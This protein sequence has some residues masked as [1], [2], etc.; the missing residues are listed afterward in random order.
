[1][2]Y[3]AGDIICFSSNDIFSIFVKIFTL[4]DISHVGIMID[5][6][7]MLEAIP[8]RIRVINIKDKLSE[9]NGTAY[10]CSLKKKHRTMIELNKTKFDKCV[11]SLI[12][13]PYD[14]G[15][16]IK[17][18]IGTLTNHKY[19]WEDNKNAEICSETD[20]I[21]LESAG[22]LKNIDPYKYTPK[23]IYNLDI[24]SKKIKIK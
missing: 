4:S 7:N 9:Y 13:K 8:P 16:I 2:G 24:Y 14:F 6:E 23:M 19:A 3:H 10:H 1:M 17:M 18:G 21:C 5:D 11:L 15:A 22:I 12:G 20:A